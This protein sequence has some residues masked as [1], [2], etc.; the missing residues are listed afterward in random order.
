MVGVM[1]SVAKDRIVK[2]MIKSVNKVKD[3]RIIGLV[4]VQSI[5][6][7]LSTNGENLH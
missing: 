5:S 4:T 6:N 3:Y 2:C 1:R 7:D